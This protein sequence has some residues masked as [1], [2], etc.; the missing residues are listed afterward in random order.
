[1][2]NAFEKVIN[3]VLAVRDTLSWRIEDQNRQRAGMMGVSQ[4]NFIEKADLVRDALNPKNLRMWVRAVSS[5]KYG[6][7]IFDSAFPKDL[8]PGEFRSTELVTD[9]SRIPVQAMGWD[10]RKALINDGV[11]MGLDREQIGI[12]FERRA[13]ERGIDTEMFF[14]RTVPIGQ[15][16]AGAKQLPK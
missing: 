10:E 3:S 14:H 13:L 5:L 7:H 16:G 8:N 4:L 12:G 6:A 11:N 1:M 15:D 2:A 9:L